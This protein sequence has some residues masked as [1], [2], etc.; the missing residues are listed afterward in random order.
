MA[1][2]SRFINRIERIPIFHSI[3]SFN[4]G[5]AVLIDFD[6]CVILHVSWRIEYMVRALLFSTP[7][8]LHQDG[9]VHQLHIILSW[10]WDFIILFLSLNKISMLC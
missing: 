2:V 9:R 1:S 8:E 5:A 3:H 7:K 4:S 10:S 6:R